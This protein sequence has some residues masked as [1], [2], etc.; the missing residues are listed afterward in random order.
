MKHGKHGMAWG[1]HVCCKDKYVYEECTP[2]SHP[3][4]MPVCLS[5]YLSIHLYLSVPFMG[6]LCLVE[7]DLSRA[8]AA[9]SCEFYHGSARTV[10]AASEKAISGG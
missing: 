2:S 5:V 9:A 6:N 8:T 7:V 3:L 4:D 10:A 1:T